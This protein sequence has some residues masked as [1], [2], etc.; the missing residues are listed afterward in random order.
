VRNPAASHELL[1]GLGA[2]QVVEKIAGE[3]DM[4]LDA[5]G[6]ATFGQAIEHVAPHGI[7]V[8]IA[9]L[10]PDETISFRAAHFDRAPGASIYTLNQFDETAAHASGTGDLNRLCGLVADGRLDGQVELEHSWREPT[11]AFEA[12]LQRRIGGKAVLHVD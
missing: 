6:G 9:T 2:T 7:V 1:R 4:V 10:R 3:F 5:V 12:L 11:P 8:N